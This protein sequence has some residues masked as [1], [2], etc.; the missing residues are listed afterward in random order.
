[1]GRAVSNNH[2]WLVALWGD[3]SIKRL[4]INWKILTV[5]LGFRLTYDYIVK[6]N[7]QNIATTI[8]NI[9]IVSSV[10]PESNR[11]VWFS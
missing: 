7:T 2:I 11:Q 6:I 8:H 4:Q 10:V 9:A 1:M 5:L 3:G